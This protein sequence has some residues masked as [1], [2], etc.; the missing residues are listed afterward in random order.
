MKRTRQVTRR[1]CEELGL[2][3]GLTVTAI[4]K[5]S[6]VHLIPAGGEK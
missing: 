4:F 1:A 5:A 6:A 3:P 2:R